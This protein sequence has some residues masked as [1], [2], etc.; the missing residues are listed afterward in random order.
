[1]GLW[2]IMKTVIFVKLSLT[3]FD[4][5]KLIATG[6]L[7][8]V[9]LVASSLIRTGVFSQ[10]EER[11]WQSF[12][13]HGLF[14]SDVQ[15]Q[16]FATEPEFIELKR[17]IQVK[18]NQYDVLFDRYYPATDS[19]D[20]VVSNMYYI[21]EH[22]NQGPISI[23]PDLYELLEFGI[24]YTKLTE[25]NFHLGIGSLTD[26]WAPYFNHLDPLGQL[27][28]SPNIEDHVEPSLNEIA[29]ARAC[30]PNYSDIDQ[31]VVLDEASHT[32]E[33]KA[34]PGC[35]T[36]ISLTVG[37]IAK[38]YATKKVA[39]AIQSLG[40]FS[41]FNSGHSSIQFDTDP[42]LTKTI[43]LINPLDPGQT[44]PAYPDYAAIVTTNNNIAFSTSGDYEQNFMIYEGESLMRRHHILDS[45]TGY[46]KNTYRAV[47]V[48]TDD[49]TLADILSTAL[50]NE[51]M[52]VG[53]TL[54]QALR[55]NGHMVEAVWLVESVV[56]E[57]PTIQI[58][59]T[60]GIHIQETT[61]EVIE[62]E[63]EAS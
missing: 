52:E 27:N 24:E 31:Y 57:E 29:A 20:Q 55:T 16:L 15:V 19:S 4:V 60:A 21:N 22:Y 35:E 49:S 56:E 47:S 38:G 14:H 48:M 18:M 9:I 36:Q 33:L 41:I 45:S 1:M 53:L 2:V 34:I 59:C 37:A 42:S 32:V 46:S 28:Q 43:Y 63:E 8:G 12:V 58:H 5:I 40:Y 7:S 3:K 11:Y 39:E 54:I 6:L 44:S 10:P 26:L 13:L 50:M 62:R 51:T 23:H 30:V 25:G 17:F 61:Y